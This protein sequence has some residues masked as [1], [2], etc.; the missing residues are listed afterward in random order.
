MQNLKLELLVPAKNKETAFAAIDA[1]AD[2]IYMGAS[3]FGA[4]KSAGNTLEDIKE[5]VDYAHKFWARVH[6]TIKSH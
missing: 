6:I 3:S 5:V 2:A 4:R 1:G